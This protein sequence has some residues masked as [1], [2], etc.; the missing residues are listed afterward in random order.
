M[1]WLFGGVPGTGNKRRLQLPK[2]NV[3]P[4][5]QYCHSKQEVPMPLAFL[6]ALLLLLLFL[7]P[8]WRQAV[9]RRPEAGGQTNIN[10]REYQAASCTPRSVYL[11]LETGQ[12]RP[13]I[14][15]LAAE[16]S[17][18]R[19]WPFPFPLPLRLSLLL[20]PL[21]PRGE[22]L[23]KGGAASGD[24]AEGTFLYLVHGDGT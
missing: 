24:R 17:H 23:I 5:G 20:L 7:L 22:L 4:F 13:T 18:F 12:K 19:N 15:L 9:G 21:G 6:G 10:S 2:N 11:Y 1:F 3:V 8:Q 14:H 16:S